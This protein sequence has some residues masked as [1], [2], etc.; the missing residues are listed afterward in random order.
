MLP[1]PPAEP[2]DPAEPPAKAEADGRVA[3]LRAAARCWSRHPRLA[4]VALTAL[5]VQQAFLTGFA[6]SLKDILSD[7]AAHRSEETLAV[8]LGILTGGFVLAALSAVVGERA[9]ARVA[10]VLT[11]DLRRDLYSHL[12]RLSPAYLLSTSP[13]KL[14]NRF[15]NNLRSVEGGYVQGFLDTTTLGMMTAIAVPLLVLLDWQLALITCLAL[16]LVVVAADRILPRLTAAT[17]EQSA[18]ELRILSTVQ[19]TARAQDV[20]R[21][22]H[23]EP[24][25][26]ERF[27]G[28]LA[29]HKTRIV[30]AR[31]IGAVAGKGA[32]LAVL[33]VQVVIVVTGAELAG[34]RELPV[35]SLVAFTTVLALLAKSVY[36]FVKTDLPLL[37]EAGRGRRGLVEM[38]AAPVVVSD[39]ANA[40]VLPPAAGAI[41]MDGVSFT[42]PG[43]SRPA[44]ED[45]S[46]AIPAG[47]TVAVV[48][49]N[50]S[51][52]S[53][54]LRLLMRY[55][56]PQQGTISI[57][58]WPL[59]DIT[60]RSLREQIGVVL[61][62]N[63]IFNDTIAE[64]IRIGR[65][66]AT[67]DEV[68]RGARQAEL[69]DWALTLADGLD[70]VVGESGGRL[71]GGQ[72]QRLAIARAMIREP[73]I[74]LLDEVTTALDP[75]TES[76]I[77]E[78]LNRVGRSRTVV[79]ATHRL[80]AATNADLIVV[81]DGGRVVEH[82]RH[83]ELL[84]ADGVYRRLWEK[85]SGF[86]VSGDGRQATVD[87]RRL[88]HV[89][90]FTDLDDE[91]LARIAVGLTSEYYE[92][93]QTV[94][95]QDDPGDRFYL[96]ARGRVAVGT[97]T[98]DGPEHVLETL[99]DGDHFGELALLQDRPRTATLRTLAPSVFLTM[100]RQ[101][102]VR[103]VA[104]TPEMGR[105][106]EERMTRSEI[107]LGEWR[108][109]VGRD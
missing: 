59:L 104:T 41:D 9:V 91:T 64:N 4:A 56:D 19:D 1:A 14:T 109:L 79:T 32:S 51:G 92:A 39:S 21:I 44:L 34:H 80:A 81:L 49:A 100:D 65:P 66:Q 17:D 30:A 82:G 62:G 29:D 53:T 93:D 86:A 35:A 73:R 10:A 103:L 2:P 71:S 31:G 7:I 25:L 46:V 24:I 76:A 96:I 57:D 43:A 78:M 15:S 95:R 94:F 107:N 67:D 12:L 13:A 60:Q 55:Y 38:F 70:T 54:L 74:L 20:V 83:D 97:G 23:L 75:I 69:H 37:A 88:R 58:G 105:M 85:Q 50:G 63:F 6:F 47:S 8:L 98:R 27:E 61:Q 99:G 101:A 106:L 68:V 89:T 108:R 26:T 11:N 42:Y 48:G 102:F 28:L 5:F 36:D 22:F 84:A 18:S 33:L 72:R 3:T 52:K 40:S 16:P 77:H 45:V 87:A 90:L